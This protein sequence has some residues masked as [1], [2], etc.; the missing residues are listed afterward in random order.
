MEGKVKDYNYKRYYVTKDGTK[1]EYSQTQSH[2]VAMGGRSDTQDYI[3]QMTKFA[4][5]KTIEL[6]RL[7]NLLKTVLRYRGYN[8]KN[9]MQRI[10]RL[11][12]AN[13]ITLKDKK[14]LRNIMKRQKLIAGDLTEMLEF[15]LM[16]YE[17]YD[18]EL[19]EMKEQL[20]QEYD[21]K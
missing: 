21:K 20:S 13:E 18:G 19:K 16:L 10:S 8:E 5:K 15:I 4:S 3:H 11:E 1:K 12:D 17:T 2:I 6:G 14:I 9:L 7:E